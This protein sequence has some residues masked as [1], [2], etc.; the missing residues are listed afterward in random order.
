MSRETKPDF[1]MW[2]RLIEKRNGVGD[3]RH[4][5][6]IFDSPILKKSSLEDAIEIEFSSKSDSLV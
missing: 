6:K 4:G 1:M 5:L 3:E 2:K